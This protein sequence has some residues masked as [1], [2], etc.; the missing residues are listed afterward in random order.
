L[1]TFVGP[2]NTNTGL[3]TATVILSG[4]SLLVYKRS[5]QNLQRLIAD[6]WRYIVAEEAL[7][8]F[9]VVFMGTMR[10][11]LPNIDSLEKYM[12]F[13]FVNQYLLNAKLPAPD[14]WF[15]GEQINYYS[16]GH[17]WSSILIRSWFVLPTVGFNL[18]L[19]FSFG[20]DLAI[21]F[22]IAINLLRGSSVIKKFLGGFFSSGLLM[23]GGNSHILWY[24]TKNWGLV[25]K[26]MNSPYWYA[27]ATRFIPQTI[28]E[29][30]SYTFTI[31][32]LHPHLI[33]LPVVLTF[34]LA[35][36]QWSR[37]IKEKMSDLYLE[38]LLGLLL[39]VMMMTNTWDGLIYTF[40]LLIYCFFRLFFDKIHW[41]IYV[42]G[43]GIIAGM[44]ILAS[45]PWWWSFRQI[46]SGFVMVEDGT[47][48]W[49]LTAV[50]SAQALFGLVAWRLFKGNMA[51]KSVVVTALF[52]IIIPEVFYF[53]DI[54]FNSPRANT[55]FKLTYQAFVMLSI[56]GGVVI[57]KTFDRMRWV[58][59]FALIIIS[60]GLL[61]YPFT[62]YPNFYLN[63]KNYYGLDGES[64]VKNI[65]PD[66][67]G[68]ISYLKEHRDGR[69]MIE[70]PGK[71]FSLSNAVSVFSGVPT[72][73]GWRDHE[74]LWRNDKAEIDKRAEE[75]AAVYE[76]PTGEVATIVI[77][78]YDLGW[79][80]VGR[81][82]RERYSIDYHGLANLGNRAWED[83]ENFLLRIGA[84][85][86]SPLV[87]MDFR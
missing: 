15:A 12:D 10:G 45:C 16:F 21:C 19:A 80:V 14:M 82:E 31:G 35:F 58:A 23:L 6:K 65:I 7:F 77:K 70:Y 2:A 63:F 37:T 79:I 20:L 74:W 4:F 68:A 75:V 78:K 36:F 40:L 32:D 28:H 9:G 34:L 48:L 66:K 52:L 71:S 69:A 3:V 62:S 33:D 85:P 59:S 51:V 25:E 54:Y 41:K 30:P 13:G 17:F 72:I 83:G 81:E 86:D 46:A 73:L 27:V 43:A 76:D 57:A 42:K 55:M 87:P 39:G 49:Q 5:H 84:Q 50:W 44:A 38:I 67:Q 24:L 64:W 60:I 56:L 22:S 53:K 29:F 61:A 11:F 26:E 47:S 8:F 18:M 1:A